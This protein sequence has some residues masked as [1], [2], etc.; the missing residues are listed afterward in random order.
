MQLRCRQE[1]SQQEQEVAEMAMK[2]KLSLITLEAEQEGPLPTNLSSLAVTLTPAL[3]L[4][5][6]LTFPAPYP[7]SRCPDTT[8]P[9]SP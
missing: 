6:S 4:T 8:T 1:R 3:S 7:L 9:S 5:R 2:H